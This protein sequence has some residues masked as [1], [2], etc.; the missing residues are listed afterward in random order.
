MFLSV[1]IGPHFT[2]S[3]FVTNARVALPL[4]NPPSVL[5]SYVSSGIVGLGLNRVVFLLS[6]LFFC[7]VLCF[8]CSL[9][10]SAPC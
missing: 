10:R 8:F 7:V 4:L 5:I 9:L 3:G 1:T 2:C 6:G